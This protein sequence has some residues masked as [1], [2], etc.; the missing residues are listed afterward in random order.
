V[1][2]GWHLWWA[3]CSTLYCPVAKNSVKNKTDH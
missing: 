1:V 2:S 3:Y